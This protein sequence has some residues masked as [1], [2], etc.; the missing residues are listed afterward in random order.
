MRR[1]SCA[2]CTP[3]TDR[4]LNTAI[5]SLLRRA[6]L[7]STNMARE[8][9][10]TSTAGHFFCSAQGRGRP[11]RLA[12][13]PSG[14][15]SSDWT[16]TKR[17]SASARSAKQKRLTQ[18]PR[19]H[20]KAIARVNSRSCSMATVPSGRTRTW[21]H[22]GFSRRT[23]SARRAAS[24]MLHSAIEARRAGGARRGAGTSRVGKTSLIQASLPAGLPST[25]RRSTSCACE[26]PW[27]H[28]GMGATKERPPWSVSS[29]PHRQQEFPHEQI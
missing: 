27:N 17:R 4:H 7:L 26:P 15:S 12:T 5:R 19:W 13:W 18:P 23:S 1:R 6:A 20:P 9:D 10:F 25:S 24:C 3:P 11:M 29:A 16:S 21:R 22:R 14:K 8:L 2:S 28:V